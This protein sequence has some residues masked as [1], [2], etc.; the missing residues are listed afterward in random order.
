[1]KKKV[2]RVLA[3]IVV[4]IG[5]LIAFIGVK[6]NKDFDVPVPDKYRASTDPEV[7]ARGKYLAFG[8]AHC[9]SCHTP[10]SR[11]TEIDKGV[12]MPLVG[13]WEVDIPPGQFRAPNLT[14][15]N[16]TGIGKLTDGQIARALRYS[17]N[18]NNKAMFP[19]MPFQELSEDDVVAII[20]FLRSQAPVKNEIKPTE[21]ALLG[22]ALIMFGA[23]KP[24]GPVNTPPKSV[25]IDST[26]AYGKYI[27]HS[28]A[29]CVGCHT[30]RD[31]QTGAAIG[32]LFAGGLKL[33]ADAMSDH[34]TFITPNLTPDKETGIIANWNEQ[35]FIN[36]FRAGRAYKGSQMPWGSF[37]RM[38]DLELKAVYRYLQTLNPVKKKIE[39]V[40]YGPGEKVPV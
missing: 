6:G 8:P 26:A 23:F 32:P 39:R 24:A 7:I 4:G 34:Y 15:D 20:S 22:K 40:A 19:F 16:E 17:V 28:V 2:F 5:A 31:L 29:N 13:G 10:L 37:S 14:P 25:T 21:Y 12:E 33:P 11:K 9:A 3:V 38:S 36:R 18:H 27:A 35:T 30:D 1:M